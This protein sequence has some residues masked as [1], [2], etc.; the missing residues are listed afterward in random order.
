MRILRVPHT[1]FPK[2]WLPGRAVN[3]LTF[4]A[5]VW[6]WFAYP[7]WPWFGGA[8]AG[9]L[10]WNSRADLPRAVELAEAR[11]PAVA[12]RFA[13]ASWEEIAGDPE[14]RAFGAAA[15]RGLYG[16]NCAPCHGQDGR[17]ARGFPDLAELVTSF[18]EAG[19]QIWGCSACTTPRGITEP[20]LIP[21]SQIVGAA[22]I[23]AAVADGAIPVALG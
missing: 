12:K 23:V 1:R 6:I 21:G 20:D 3:F 10:G 7:A 2:G 4:L 8:T 13:A 11:A 22:T 14:L 17:G 19:G 15:G 5:A 16:E 9:W 18:V